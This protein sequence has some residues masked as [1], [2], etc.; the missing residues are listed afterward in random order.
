MCH[1]LKS[2]DRQLAREDLKNHPLSEWKDDCIAM[3]YRILFDRRLRKELHV[4]SRN[5]KN[6]CSS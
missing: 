5:E 6:T 4:R 2:R 1:K 3:L